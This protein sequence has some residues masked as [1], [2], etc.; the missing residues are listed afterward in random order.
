[1]RLGRRLARALGRRKGLTRLDVPVLIAP[2]VSATAPYLSSAR[3]APA[4]SPPTGTPFGGPNA[5]I[6][7]A[8][9]TILARL[10]IGGDAANIIRNPLQ[11]NMAV[12][13]VRLPWNPIFGPG[14]PIGPIPPIDSIALPQLP[15]LPAPPPQFS[16]ELSAATECVFRGVSPAT[17]RSLRQIIANSGV[18]QSLRA[19]WL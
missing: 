18:N 8:R 1:M 14:F 12:G 10:G 4:P 5:L 11:I 15:P 19:R 17:S 7:Q 3:P 2:T 16:S 9:E 6:P 13:P